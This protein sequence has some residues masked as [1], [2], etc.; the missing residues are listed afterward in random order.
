M[1]KITF[2]DFKS[3]YDKLNMQCFIAF[4][5]QNWE[6]TCAFTKNNYVSPTLA[7]VG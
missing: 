3:Y 7:N 1:N 5:S 6:N 2:T 4:D